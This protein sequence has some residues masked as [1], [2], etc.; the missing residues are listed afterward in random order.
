M[1]GK[2]PKHVVPARERWYSRHWCLVNG[3]IARNQALE[4]GY[5]H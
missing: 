5:G 2:C 1:S 3:A 4:V